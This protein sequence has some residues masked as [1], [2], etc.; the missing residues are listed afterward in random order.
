LQARAQVLFAEG[1]LEQAEALFGRILERVPASEV[2]GRAH[3]LSNLGNVRSAMGQ[4]EEALAWFERAAAEARKAPVDRELLATVRL[5]AANVLSR[6][7]RI[8][9]ALAAADESLALR[10]A[11][12]GERHVKTVP[13]YI[14]RAY[15]L[16][17]A[18]RWDDA[19]AAAEKAAALE[20]ELAGGA[21][22]RLAAIYR[23]KGLA[24]DRKGDNAAAR[25]G[26][27]AALEVQERLLPEDHYDLAVTRSNLASAMMAQGEYE[28]SLGLLMKAWRVHQANSDGQPSRSR[29][30]AEV[31]I[32]WCH[33]R[34]DRPAKGLEW[35]EKALRGA[36]QVIEP[37]QWILGHFRNVYAEA[38]LA[39]DRLEEARG[40]AQQVAALYESS[41]VPVRRKSLQDNL[42]LLARISDRSGDAERAAD[43][44][45][46]LSELVDESAGE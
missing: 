20:R 26:F 23:A 25:E 16:M 11:M 5:N 17:A 44:R 10:V 37:D 43:Y 13:S 15:V 32:A 1:D 18:G 42:S 6:T 24:A 3:V 41:E 29:A 36:E 12:Y 9:E 34:L 40:E 33:L 28:E 2:D 21:S 38:L 14:I 22:R 46:R 8:E 27:G 45:E 31:N 39:N 7:G 4:P 19:I 30:I 35:A